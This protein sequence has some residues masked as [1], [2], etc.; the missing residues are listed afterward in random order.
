MLQRR[1]RAMMRVTNLHN[2]EFRV[3][4]NRERDANEAL[5]EQ[6]AVGPLA[7]LFSR[8]IG[9]G[10]VSAIHGAKNGIFTMAG[11]E[12]FLD[13]RWSYG[14]GI[15]RL[16]AGDTGAAV[17]PQA[18]KEWVCGI[19]RACSAYCS[20]GAGGIGKILQIGIEPCCHHGNR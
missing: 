10:T 14:P 8:Y 5:A 18:L 6:H 12:A 13:V 19:N 4:R 7:R 1:F 16:M 15:P 3:C 2:I 20:H 9:A 17:G 11:G